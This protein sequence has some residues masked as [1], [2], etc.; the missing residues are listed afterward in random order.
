MTES[1]EEFQKKYAR[2]EKALDVLA[3]KYH[4]A[5]EEKRDG[6]PISEITDVMQASTYFK[7]IDIIGGL[8]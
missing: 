6:I 3:D 4:K 1:W 8:K 7:E 5:I 2:M